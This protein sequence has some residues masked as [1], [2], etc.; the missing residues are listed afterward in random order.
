MLS[1]LAEAQ[2]DGGDVER[3][4]FLI[5][6]AAT[7]T[8]TAVGIPVGQSVGQRVFES[9]ARDDSELLST[10]Q[11]THTTDW[12]IS[13]YV[14]R[15]GAAA[16]ALAAWMRDESSTVLRVNAAGILAKLGAPS[17]TQNV[18]A[19]LRCDDESRRLY[20]TAV[21]NRVLRLPWDDAIERVSSL[22]GGRRAASWLTG[23]QAALLAIEARDGRDGAARW[24]SAVL[25]GTG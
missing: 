24:C 9:I 1:M 23:D 18:I 4:Q 14:L 13:R 20:L 16:A 19:S 2:R 10:V 22:S 15:D 8:A 11:T 3:R 5:G 6:M 7:M 12:E 17:V 25:L 21:V